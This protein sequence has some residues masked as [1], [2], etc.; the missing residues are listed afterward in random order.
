MSRSSEICERICAPMTLLQFAYSMLA[1]SYLV[2][3]V[4]LW[5]GY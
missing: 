1:V 5:A 2:A 3:V 4:A